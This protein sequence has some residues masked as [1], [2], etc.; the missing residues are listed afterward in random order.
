MAAPFTGSVSILGLAEI[1][2]KLKMSVLVDPAVTE[3]VG[4]FQKRG[5]RQGRGVGAKRNTITPE[6]ISPIGVRLIS[7][8][9]PP[10]TRSTSRNRKIMAAWQA[11]KSRVLRKAVRRITERWAS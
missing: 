2:R 1:E 7:T 6:A 11:M 3:A 5:E 8:L 10:R 4:S 9:N